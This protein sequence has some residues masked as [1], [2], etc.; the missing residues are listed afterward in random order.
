MTV[1]N[2]LTRLALV[3][4]AEQL[5]YFWY[6]FKFRYGKHL[7]LKVPVDVSLELSSTCNMSCRYCYH[8]NPKPPFEKKLMKKETAFKIIKEAADLGVNSLKFNYRGESSL[9]PWFGE[10]TAYA[11]SLSKG[12]TFIERISNSNFKFNNNRADIFDGFANNTKVKISFDSFKKEV[13]ETQRAGGVHE[14][15][16]KNVDTFYNWKKR[17][18]N[19]TEIVIQAVRT[20]LNKDEDIYGEVKKRWP[21]ATISIR[22]MV[23]GRIDNDLSGLENKTRDVNERQSCLQAHVRLMFAWDGRAGVCCPDIKNELVVGDINK[24]SLKEIFN[25]QLAKKI[26]KDLKSGEAFKLNPCKGCSSF[27]SYKGFKPSWTS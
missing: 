6:R 27:E 2:F 20:K 21:S 25:S 5:N 11:R 16:L 24:Q 26:R 7:P 9:N 15:T 3:N 12:S 23:G 8:N 1:L 17:I 19:D 18:E 10:I 22:D 14:I 4:I 13:F